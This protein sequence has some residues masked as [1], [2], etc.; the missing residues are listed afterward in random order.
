V[1]ADRLAIGVEHEK[2]WADIAQG[3]IE[4]ATD[5]GAPGYAAVI[6]G[7]AT[8]IDRLVG[9]DVLGRVTLVVASIQNGTAGSSFEAGSPTASTFAD[10]MAWFTTV[11]AASRQLLH[12][13]GLLAVVASPVRH[14]GSWYD[15]PAASEHAALQAGYLPAD[16]LNA[17]ITPGMLRL[18]HPANSQ[19][20][21]PAPMN[22]AD[23]R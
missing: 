5:S 17:H 18:C 19:P 20:I 7:D 22:L 6:H 15:V 21:M 14:A 23:H 11:L 3:R 1:K 12:P 8:T 16:D 9:R 13:H 2:Y 4:S 10:A